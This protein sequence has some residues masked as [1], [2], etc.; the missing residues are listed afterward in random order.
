MQE[1]G[2]NDQDLLLDGDENDLLMADIE[3]EQA[4]VMA[5]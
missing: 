1:I 3:D 2:E 4:V 5:K